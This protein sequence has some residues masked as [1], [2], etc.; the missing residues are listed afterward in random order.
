MEVTSKGLHEVNG[1]GQTAEGIFVAETP[2][3]AEE[4]DWLFSLCRCPQNLDRS[5]SPHDS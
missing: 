2:K 5:F 3:Q 1:G 4:A